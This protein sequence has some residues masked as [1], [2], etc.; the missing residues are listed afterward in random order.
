VNP[1]S[2][3]DVRTVAQAG[4]WTDLC[5]I[6]TIWHDGSATAGGTAV[7][8]ATITTVA[9]TT[10][11]ITLTINGSADT[12]IGGGADGVVDLME[13]GYDTCGEV[14]DHINSVQGWNCRLE[15]V[16]RAS[17]LKDATR[18]IVIAAAEQTC[19]KTGV[20]ILRDSDVTSKAAGFEHGWVI[21]QRAVKTARGKYG[22]IRA[23]EHEHGYR[24]ILDKLSV[25]L[26][27][28]ADSAV[29]YVYQVKGTTEEL[30]HSQT[31]AATTV[32]G[33]WTP[34]SPIIADPGYHLL[35]IAIN[36]SAVTAAVS[37]IHGRSVKGAVVEL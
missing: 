8:A 12:R 15:G 1:N 13:A 3:K 37:D 4:T 19:Y 30:V 35:I 34:A 14:Y 32:A 10:N 23:I 33:T 20:A 25:T 7:T 18:A 28:A 27:Y 9:G 36:V 24:N 26:T 31:A 11:T 21:S 22:K 29:I 5:P 17:L 16:L 6:M 2:V